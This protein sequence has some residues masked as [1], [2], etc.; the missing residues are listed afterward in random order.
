MQYPFGKDGIG[1][2]FLFDSD[3]NLK[4][5]FGG[6]LGP[7][8]LN[9]DN[10]QFV[11]LGTA[12]RWF[13]HVYRFEEEGR[14]SQRADVFQVEPTF[15]LAFRVWSNDSLAWTTEPYSSRDDF[16]FSHFFKPVGLDN[17]VK[18]Q[19][20]DGQPYHL[21]IG[22]DANNN[23]FRGPSRITHNDSE[24]FAVDLDSSKRFNAV[25]RHDN[26]TRP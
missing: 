10:V 18:A 8:D 17:A 26:Q 14:Y 12:D 15:P 20:A 5:R 4:A 22:W 3:G 25:G 7:D 21:I 11:T 1:V 23:V 2:C 9:G 16:E 19:G 24:V 13:V 6:E